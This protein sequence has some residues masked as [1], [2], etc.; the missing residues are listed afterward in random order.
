M[1]NTEKDSKEEIGKLYASVIA[2]IYHEYHH[3]PFDDINKHNDGIIKAM[4]E[5]A[6]FYK[7]HTKIK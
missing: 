1:I 5:F 3:N 7:E 4:I 2:D 6:V